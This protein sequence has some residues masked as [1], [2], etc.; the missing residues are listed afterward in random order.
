VY[1]FA[2][3]FSLA[4]PSPFVLYFLVVFSF[5]MITNVDMSR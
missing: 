4:Y 1:L 5:A 3:L 2:K